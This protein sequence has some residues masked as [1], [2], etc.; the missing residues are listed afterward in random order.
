MAAENWQFGEENTAS[1]GHI[2]IERNHDNLKTRWS[3]DEYNDDLNGFL[4]G[5][6]C[7]SFFT[8]NEERGWSIIPNG[9]V[10]DERF[11]HFIFNPRSDNRY[12]GSKNAVFD[13]GDYNAQDNNRI[14]YTGQAWDDNDNLAFAEDFEGNIYSFRDINT[15]YDALRE[16]VQTLSDHAVNK[17]V[18]LFVDVGSSFLTELNNVMDDND[19]LCFHV[20]NS[21][22]SLADSA[23]DLKDLW[24]DGFYSNKMHCWWYTADITVP[25]YDTS[26]GNSPRTPYNYSFHSGGSVNM[27]NTYDDDPDSI[28]ITQEWMNDDGDDDDDDGDGDG[29]GDGDDYD[30]DDYD[31]DED[32]DYD[33]DEDDDDDD[34]GDD[35]DDGYGDDNIFW[36]T[37]DACNA[38]CKSQVNND[39]EEITGN[40]SY[41]SDKRSLCYMRKRSG[42][43]F[44]IWF[45]EQF[46]TILYEDGAQHF[47]HTCGFGDK[48]PA[49]EPG[50]G[51]LDSLAEYGKG[52]HEFDD[53]EHER[54]VKKS[55]IRSQSFF[56]TGDWPAA[57]WAAY[58]HC[59]FIFH[60]VVNSSE[61]VL[62]FI[63]D[64]A[65]VQY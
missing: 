22:C 37:R 47:E 62:I 29:D 32:E 25:L 40:D 50:Y 10:S 24:D 23:D 34:Y 14:Q 53:A 55:E 18:Y 28:E 56:V 44:Q 21:Q 20:I 17:T 43:G 42:D 49:Y 60:R 11:V 26:D 33:E 52:S 6:Q 65:G 5:A 4:W 35:D 57:C 1:C 41:D 51:L 19:K 58:C 12:T 9:K 59:N 13:L 45:M 46:A 63:A 31:E 16:I 64:P 48:K 7:E 30:E 15:D 39:F 36:R 54:L 8:D 27:Y 61:E 3:M 38:N 2:D